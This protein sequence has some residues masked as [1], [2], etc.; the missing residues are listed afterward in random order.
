M[1]TIG[2][3]MITENNTNNKFCVVFYIKDISD[4]NKVTANIVSIISD[5]LEYS[6]SIEVHIDTERGSESFNESFNEEVDKWKK[7]LSGF[8]TKV[9]Y[10]ESEHSIVNVIDNSE[11]S[12]PSDSI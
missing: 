9:C 5:C 1:Q 12:F 4:F 10:N 11:S 8:L 7:S 3:N 2:S 6:I